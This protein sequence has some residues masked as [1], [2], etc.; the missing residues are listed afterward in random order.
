M[1]ALLERV[2]GGAT[3]T[4][5]P[6]TYDVP[7]GMDAETFYSPGKVRSIL[8]QWPDYLEY[9]RPTQNGIRYDGNLSQPTP[10]RKLGD[11]TRYV[12]IMC[13][14]ERAWSKLHRWSIEFQVVEWTMQGYELAEIARRLRVPFGDA[15][16]AFDKACLLIARQLGWRG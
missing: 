7:A 13:D 14:I 11:C 9:A 16:R 8:E 4:E 10:G 1:V 15:M 5:E 2:G 12:D 6:A 3:V